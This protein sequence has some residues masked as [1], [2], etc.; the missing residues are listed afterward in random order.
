M[1]AILALLAAVAMIGSAAAWDICEELKYT[2]TKTGYEQA[3]A[4]I[5]DQFINT[6]SGAYAEQ[7]NTEYGAAWL[8]IDN[9]LL[10]VEID[11]EQGPGGLVN[12]SYSAENN[13]FYTQLTQGGDAKLCFSAQDTVAG[14]PEISGEASAYQNLWVG[15]EFARTSAEFDSRAI[16]GFSDIP[17]DAPT[18]T[19]TKH[20]VVTDVISATSTIDADEYGAG[21]FNTANMGVKVDADIKQDYVGSGWAEPTYS[22]GITMWANFDGACDPHCSNPIIT[23]VIGSAATAIFPPDDQQLAAGLGSGEVAYWG[24]LW[25]TNPQSTFG[26][27]NPHWDSAPAVPA[28]APW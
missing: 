23:E 19:D 18:Q 21:Y 27:W 1:K 6:T 16:V 9:T 8:K 14:G 15:G 3:G 28:P 26:E 24:A 12:P 4:G 13:N 20:F 22:G 5:I 2:Y 10:D 17:A 7:P 25:M 11:R